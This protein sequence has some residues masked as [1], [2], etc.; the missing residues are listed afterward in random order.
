MFEPRMLLRRAYHLHLMLRSVVAPS[1]GC[2]SLVLVVGLGGLILLFGTTGV[3]DGALSGTKLT[4]V[5]N[6][7]SGFFFG[8][9]FDCSFCSCWWGYLPKAAD[10]GADLVGKVEAG[11]LRM[12]LVAATIAD[13]VGDNVGDVEVWVLIFSRVGVGAIIGSMVL[14]IGWMNVAPAEIGNNPVLLPLFIAAAGIVISILCTFMVKTKEGGNP[15]TALDTGTFMAAGIMLIVSYFL[16]TF[17]LGDATY[18]VPGSKDGLAVGVFF[19]VLGG[20]VSGTLI[21]I[22]TKYYTSNHKAPVQG[23]AKESTTGPATNI[24]SGLGV[25][26]WSTAIPTILICASILIAYKFAGLYGVAMAALG[27][28]CTTG[29]QLAVDAYG[30]IADN[31]GG[32]A[33]M[34]HLDPEVRNRTDKL[35]AVGNTTAAIGKGFR[36][37]G[38]YSVGAIC[39]LCSEGWSS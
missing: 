19:A 7:V 36:F 35:D 33:E 29:I 1:W 16:I 9:Q 21:G 15:Q 32:I 4:L 2:Q 31:A 26:M 22:V 28:L 38:T 5:L 13:N 23:I 24:I 10:V 17:F 30:P 37:S 34:A 39:C 25:G 11:I 8:R 18:K 6:V 14:G 3:I 12:T 27:M 20:L